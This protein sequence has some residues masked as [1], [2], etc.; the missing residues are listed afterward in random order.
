MKPYAVVIGSMNC[1]TIYL[2]DRLPERGE[3]YFARSASI[4][5]GGKG[6]NQAVQLSKLGIKTYMVGKLGDDDYGRFLARE[7]SACGV[8]M[9]RVLTGRGTTGVAAVL[10]MPDGVYHSTVAPGTNYEMDPAELD[11]LRELISGAAVAVFQNEITPSVTELG[12]RMAHEAGV[13][14][15][16]NAAPART[17]P[18]ACM[19]LVDC[20]I[21]N[22]SEA[23]FYLGQ[24]IDSV[25][26]AC[27]YAERLR[28]QTGGILVITLGGSGSVLCTADGCTHYPV[29]TSI[30]AVETTGSGDSYVGALA[31]MKANGL[32]D[33]AA[34]RFASL[35]SQYTVTRI[36][37]QP[38][39]PRWKDIAEAWKREEL[40]NRTEETVLFTNIKT[41]VKTK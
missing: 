38:A 15:I 13:Y 24:T 4:V 19:K 26:R 3:T 8:D 16:L 11:G 5:P 25:E 34:C 17:I 6:A 29:D 37:G 12:I 9:S 7:M 40:G 22:E 32:P 14:V 1:D 10:T 36:G 41:E 2:Q 27:Q 20:L 31:F 28:S 35:V 39:M 33:D 18:E 23:S 21:V 30:K